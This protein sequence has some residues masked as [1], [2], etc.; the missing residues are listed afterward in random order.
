MKAAM[1][2]TRTVGMTK[3]SHARAVRAYYHSFESILGYRLFLNGVKHCGW[4][5]KQF[6]QQQ[7]S[8][9]AGIE[10]L[11]IRRAV[12]SHTKQRTERSTRCSSDVVLRNTG[13]NRRR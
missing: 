10:N 4:R 8:A 5:A 9:V 12:V 6:E 11:R 13:Y 7:S 1:A 3:V 2:H